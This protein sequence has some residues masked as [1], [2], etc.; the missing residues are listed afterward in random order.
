M[1]MTLDAVEITYDFQT[2]YA[3]RI[4]DRWWLFKN[5][6]DLLL[7]LDSH[8]NPTLTGARASWFAWTC[9]LLHRYLCDYSLPTIVN[10]TG[11]DIKDIFKVT[12]KPFSLF[13]PNAFFKRNQCS[14]LRRRR[15]RSWSA[16]TSS[17][18]RW[19]EFLTWQKTDHDWWIRKGREV[20][21]TDGWQL[22][23]DGRPTGDWLLGLF[24]SVFSAWTSL[25]HNSVIGPVVVVLM[26]STNL[27]T[28]LSQRQW[29]S[30]II[31]L[32][33]GS[34]ETS[35]HDIWGC[36][37]T[38]SKIVLIDNWTGGTTKSSTGTHPSFFKQP[39]E[40]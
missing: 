8:R 4:S 20:N 17:S 14:Q 24:S 33:A 35:S 2:E 18:D 7:D 9:F 3:W 31:R 34:S 39:S 16:R 19:W 29:H 6:T 22:E 38:P 13:P 26:L 37:V 12:A 5:H 40:G 23:L 1:T 10:I 28:C 32:N 27:V 21:F 15:H 25:W 36:A 11:G 30:E